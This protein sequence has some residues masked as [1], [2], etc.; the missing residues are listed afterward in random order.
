MFCFLANHMY[1]ALGCCEPLQV[2]YKAEAWGPCFTKR[3]ATCLSVTNPH[4]RSK[5]KASA[6]MIWNSHIAFLTFHGTCRQSF[7]MLCRAI[8]AS[9]IFWRVC[10]SLHKVDAGIIVES[11]AFPWGPCQ[12]V[13]RKLCGHKTYL[14]HNVCYG[15]IFARAQL[16]SP[17]CQELQVIVEVMCFKH[18]LACLQRLHQKNFH[19]EG[20]SSPIT[21]NQDK[22]SDT[23]TK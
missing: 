16:E 14:V 4:T 17:R 7:Q 19:W 9:N 12:H 13:V 23:M 2:S 3:V 5:P 22:L 8:L 15:N 6:N 18:R 11:I 1:R 10:R 21:T 20:C